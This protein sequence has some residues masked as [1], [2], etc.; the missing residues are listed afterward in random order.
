MWSYHEH[1][2]MVVTRQRQAQV[3]TKERPR[4]A[5]SVG[6]F[7]AADGST[8]GLGVEQALG[9]GAHTSQM[10]RLTK[11]EIESR[12]FSLWFH[13]KVHRMRPKQRAAMIAEGVRLF[14]LLKRK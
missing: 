10:K 5:C 11:R 14:R 6:G 8:N 1:K 13:L 3:S 9:L 2:T 4:E 12:M 7:A